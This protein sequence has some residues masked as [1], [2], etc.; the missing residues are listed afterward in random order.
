VSRE[1]LYVSDAAEGILLAT[2]LYDKSEPVNLGV[3]QEIFIRDLVNLIVQLS[4]FEGHVRWDASK[5][6]GQ[7][8]RC[9]D[10][11]RAQREFGFKA[12][13][14]LEVGLRKT[15]DWYREQMRT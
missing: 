8:R 4:G 3:G 10:T 6:D 13:T 1:F 11:T 2:E 7:P 14:T 5:P 9:L 15:I 12:K